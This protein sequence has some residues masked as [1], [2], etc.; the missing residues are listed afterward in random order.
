MSTSR[1]PPRYSP[2]ALGLADAADVADGEK[3]RASQA[4]LRLVHLLL[5]CWRTNCSIEVFI[6]WKIRPHERGRAAGQKSPLEVRV[7]HVQAACR[8][9]LGVGIPLFSSSARQQIMS[10]FIITW[11]TRISRVNTAQGLMD[12]R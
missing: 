2:A 10:A 5:R 12:A 6:R 7:S 3:G 11:M 4:R 8:L 1:T 9:L